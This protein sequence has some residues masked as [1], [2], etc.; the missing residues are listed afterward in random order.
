VVL[1]T[2]ETGNLIHEALDN[3]GEFSITVVGGF[4]ALE[5]NVR[6]LGADFGVRSFGTESAGAELFD[7]LNVEEALHIGI[8]EEFDLLD[9]VRS[10]ETVEEGQERDFALERGEMS[11]DREVMSFLNGGGTGHGEA[12]RAA[13]H[14]VRVV[15]EN[16]QR[17]GGQSAGGNMEHGRQHFAGDLVHVRDHQEQTLRS[18]IGGGESTGAESTVNRTGGAGFGLH[19]RDFHNFAEH[20][21][22]ALAGPGIGIFT[23]R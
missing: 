12:G 6:V 1:T 5:V 21:F 3:A 9:F 18:G 7:V 4:A 8:V 23:H 10:T 2:G 19:F 11:H 14:N 17:L 15:A 16:R 13:G 22:H 20:V